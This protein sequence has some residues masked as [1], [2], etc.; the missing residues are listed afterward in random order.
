VGPYTIGSEKVSAIPSLIAEA[1]SSWFVTIKPGAP[2]AQI[3]A[4]SEEQPALFARRANVP[5]RTALIATANHLHLSRYPASQEGRIAIVT[6]VGCGMRWTLW[7]R[8]TSGA[9]SGRR[10][11]VV[12]TPRRWRQVG[13]SVSAGDSGKKARSLGR[14]RRKPL[15]PLR[16][17]C[18]VFS[19][20]LVVTNARAFYTTRAAAGAAGTRHSLRPLSRGT[21]LMQTSGAIAPRECGP[22]PREPSK[23]SSLCRHSGARASASKPG[24]SRFRV[25][26]FGPSRND[27]RDMPS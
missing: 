25:W 14:A 16:G 9:R 2:V 5:Q 7:R 1:N 20:V 15:K 18:R 12:L 11:R 3:S 27:G 8:K 17:E 13:G 6:D 23:Q 4:T 19:G 26:S 21:R 10:S 22:M 24:I